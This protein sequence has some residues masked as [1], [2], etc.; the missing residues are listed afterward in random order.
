MFYLPFLSPSSARS[1]YNA[2]SIAHVIIDGDAM[3]KSPVGCI[4]IE[5]ICTVLHMHA[6]GKF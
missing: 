5:N 4:W 6:C 2:S 1:I 3:E